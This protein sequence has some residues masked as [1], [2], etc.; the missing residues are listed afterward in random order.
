[1]PMLVVVLAENIYAD[2][3]LE[4]VSQKGDVLYVSW[5]SS[6]SQDAMMMARPMGVGSYSAGLV[7]RTSKVKFKD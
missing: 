4:K 2:L 6:L 7:P 5:Q 3:S 1:M